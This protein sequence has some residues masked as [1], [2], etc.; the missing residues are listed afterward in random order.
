M[1]HVVS[2]MLEWPDSQEA[3]VQVQ[4]MQQQPPGQVT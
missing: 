3:D 4:V 1:I 2:A